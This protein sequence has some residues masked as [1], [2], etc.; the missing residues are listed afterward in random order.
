MSSLIDQIAEQ[1]IMKAIEEGQLKYLA[2]HGKPL[3]LED[4]R[5]VPEH[6]RV[7]YRILKN[8]GYIPPEL[9]DRN[10]AL[11]MCDLLDQ[12]RKSSYAEVETIKKLREIELRMKIRGVDTRF[13]YQ[14]LHRNKTD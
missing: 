10:S 6:L 12:C 1:R 9:E 2:G 5:M 13:I 11:K 8:A 14:Y 7:G 4:D 3:E